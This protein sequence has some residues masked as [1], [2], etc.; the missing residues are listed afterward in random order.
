MS[1]IS[2]SLTAKLTVG[3]LSVALSLYVVVAGLLFLQS[4]YMIRQLAREHAASVLNTALQQVINQ[5]NLVETAANANLWLAEAYFEPDSLKALARSIVNHNRHTYGCLIAN[6]SGVFTSIR[7]T[8]YKYP[9][10]AWYQ[11]A[12]ATG[13]GDWVV[14]NREDTQ[15]QTGL[16]RTLAIYSRPIIRQGKAVGVLSTGMSFRQMSEMIYSMDYPYPNAYFVVQDG[17]GRILLHPDSTLLFTKTA[18]GNQKSGKDYVFS[19]AIPKTDWSLTMVCPAGDVM[20]NYHS[21]VL[22][23]VILDILGMLLITLLVCWGV[24][25]ALA[26][27]GSLAEMSDQIATGHYE[28]TIPVSMREDAVGRMQNSFVGMQYSLMN[29]VVSIKRATERLRIHNEKLDSAMKQEEEALKRK[30]LFLQNV[31]HQIRTPLNIIMGFG[32]VLRDEKLKT[33]DGGSM[34]MGDEELKNIIL[35]MKHNA[36]HLNRM[37]MMLYDSSEMGT[38]EEK[39]LRCEELVSCNAVARE[40]IDFTKENFPDVPIEFYTELPDSTTIVTNH[41]FLM[42]TIR[43]LVYN[44]AKYSDAVWIRVS[45]TE[46]ASTVQFTIED[47][48]PGLP[49]AMNYEFFTK[50]NDLS[51]GL[52]LGLPLTK[53]HAENLG[54]N[55]VHDESYHDGCRFVITMPK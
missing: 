10:E 34:D 6:Q 38:I 5:M 8:E 45:V 49:E 54:G 23:V 7:E 28:C 51:E 9:E 20:A 40:C 35:M 48:G 19:S 52:G 32:Q 3:V 44:A 15:G 17:E 2:R 25:R 46:T 27:I 50:L 16:D 37:V 18:L 26:P 55:M 41:L 42:R 33:A 11:Q 21:M 29:N 39:T 30:T 13:K 24:R 43:E 47:K 14:L 53:R 1:R 22:L 31:M 12:L 4:R 36:V